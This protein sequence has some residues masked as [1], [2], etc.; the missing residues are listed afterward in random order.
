[1]N[2]AHYD[3]GHDRILIDG[4]YDVFGDGSVV[5][6][7]THGHTPGHQSLRLRLDCGTV[8]LTADAC[9]MRKTLADSH[10]PGIVSDRETML[11]SLKFLKS[12]QAKGDHLVFGHDPDQWA[13][14][15][16]G[17]LSLLDIDAIAKFS[18]PGSD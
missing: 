15:C 12:C 14:I 8:I 7:P 9:Y 6:L 4:E 1:M 10:L 17:P 16:A 18:S 13:A 11:R 5:C 3:L 2:P